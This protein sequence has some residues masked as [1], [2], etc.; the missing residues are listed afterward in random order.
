MTTKPS[1]QTPACKIA[2]HPPVSYFQIHMF[3]LL[4]AL[5]VL[6]VSLPVAAGEG[7][8]RLCQLP[9]ADGCCCHRGSKGAAA[10]PPASTHTLAKRCCCSMEQ[11]S[12][13]PAPQPVIAEHSLGPSD[14]QPVAVPTA[15]VLV[16]PIQADAT[17]WVPRHAQPPW[18][19]QALGSVRL[20]P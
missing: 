2:T 15:R 18:Q 12:G 20:R 3:R 10:D 1:T 19:V 6:L 5:L 7:W 11:G 13:D 17:R 4:S 9:V 8:L 14:L 16:L